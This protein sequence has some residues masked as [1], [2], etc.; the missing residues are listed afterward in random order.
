M[1]EKGITIKTGETVKEL[2]ADENNKVTAVATDKGTY[3]AD[4]VINS[5]GVVPNTEWLNGIL[6]LDQKG[7]IQVDE[8]MQTSV[9]DVYAA[10]DATA[11][12]FAPTNKWSGLY[13]PSHK[14]SSSRDCHGPSCKWRHRC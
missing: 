4:T 6:D 12:P 9:T 11:I 7:F 10:G 14:R 8:H 1:T 13:C 2:Q 5:T 3:E